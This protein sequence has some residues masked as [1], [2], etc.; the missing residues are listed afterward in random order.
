LLADS[1]SEQERHAAFKDHNHRQVL[2]AQTH[3]INFKIFTTQN[4]I[5]TVP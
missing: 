4:T 2:S 5:Y 1:S 3:N